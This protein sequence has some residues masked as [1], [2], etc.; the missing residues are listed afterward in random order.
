[1]AST[2]TTVIT[3]PDGSMIKSTTTTT[4]SFD[5]DTAAAQPGDVTKSANGALAFKFEVKGQAGQIPSVGLGTATLFDDECTAAVRTAI[6]AGYRHIDTALLY[7]N[8]AA[9]GEGIRQA[10]AAGEVTREELWVTSKIGFFPEDAVLFPPCPPPPARRYLP[11][12]PCLSAGA[13]SRPGQH[14]HCCVL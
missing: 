13:S 3:H 12:G 8:Q 4:A 2:T 11:A 7:N 5:G 14:C 1:M 6:R 9:V 10:I